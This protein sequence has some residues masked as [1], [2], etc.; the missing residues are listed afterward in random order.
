MGYQT[1]KI[2][3]NKKTGA[4]KM[5]GDGFVGNTCDVLADIENQIGIVAK[6][7]DKPERYLY[8]QPDYLPQG[9]L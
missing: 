6:T 2:E 4:V 9:S 7:E 5:E 8:Q 3:I 1:V